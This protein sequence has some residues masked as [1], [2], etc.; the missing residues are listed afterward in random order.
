MKKRKRFLSQEPKQVGKNKRS[1]CRMCTLCQ[2]YGIFMLASSAETMHWLPCQWLVPPSSTY[3]QHCEFNYAHADQW[4]PFESWSSVAWNTLLFRPVMPKNDRPPSLLMTAHSLT[5]SQQRL[6]SLTL[7]DLEIWLFSLVLSSI[8]APLGSKCLPS[9]AKFDMHHVIWLLLYIVDPQCRATVSLSFRSA[10]SWI[11]LKLNKVDSSSTLQ[12]P[13][14]NS[15]HPLSLSHVAISCGIWA[16]VTHV[17]HAPCWL[18][19]CIFLP[20]RS[21]CLWSHVCTASPLTCCS[22]TW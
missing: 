10:L 9:H 5:Q 22:P 13:V 20:C 18:L 17:S 11:K 8:H 6:T 2:N 19:P 12:T 7:I 14:R 15:H 16:F 1:K 4:Q 3:C 21:L